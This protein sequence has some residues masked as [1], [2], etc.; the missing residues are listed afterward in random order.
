MPGEQGPEGPPGPYGLANLVYHSETRVQ[1]T[2]NSVQDQN[3]VCPDNLQIISA[4]WRV[5]D[6]NP[7]SLYAHGSWPNE[8][9][10]SRWDFQFRYAGTG[11]NTA[12]LQLW[13][14]CAQSDLTENSWPENY[15]HD[16]AP[17]E[18]VDV[19]NPITGR[20]W[21]DR[22]LG[23][24]RAATS[25]TDEEAYGSFFQWGRFADG[26]QRRSHVQTTSVLSS[27]DNPGR[28]RE[29]KKPRV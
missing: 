15:E 14:L 28:F 10:R 8:N 26:H 5:V 18:I 3:I 16:G 19:T 9:N 17:T 21:M 4:G 23:A 13:A 22:N 20:T 29:L 1:Q 24:T 2:N 27:T 11:N 6:L 12:T 25:P 7:F